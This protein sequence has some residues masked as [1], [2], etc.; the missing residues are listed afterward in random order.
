MSF[1][2]LAPSYMC[3]FTC[4]YIKPQCALLL[5]NFNLMCSSDKACTLFGAYFHVTVIVNVTLTVTG[6]SVTVRVQTDLS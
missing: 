6:T 5:T 4:K 2:Y 1:G 3:K